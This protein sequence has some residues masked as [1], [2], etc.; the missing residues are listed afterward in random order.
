MRFP[1]PRIIRDIDKGFQ[2]G[3]DLWGQHGRQQYGALVS[4]K[5]DNWTHETPADQR[6]PVHR[7]TIH[8]RSVST[9]STAAGK[10]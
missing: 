3:V 8:R 9:C 7:Q 10:H 6:K 1:L 2:S 4:R 5:S